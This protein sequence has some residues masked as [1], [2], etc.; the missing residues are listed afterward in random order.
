MNSKLSA[1]N[2]NSIWETV[3]NQ[4]LPILLPILYHD[5]ASSY[6]INIMAIDNL[7]TQ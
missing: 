6:I 2:Q 7:A 5:S 1:A 3:T 4:P